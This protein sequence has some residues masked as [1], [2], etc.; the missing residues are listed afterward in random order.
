VEALSA[1]A[2]YSRY[3]FHRQFSALF[4][5]NVHR[6]VLFSRMQRAS[7]LLAFRPHLHVGD[8]AAACGYDGPE[9]FARAFRVLVGDSP[10]G[11]RAQPDW[12]AWSERFHDFLSL[13]RLTM[14]A[15]PSLQDVQIV[16]FPATP[17][18]L[19]THRGDLRTLNDSIRLF[20]DWRK[21]NSVAPRNSATFN[22]LFDDP[23]ATATAD[24]RFGLAAAT[25]RPIEPNDVGVVPMTLPAGRC[26]RLRH[27]G[28][29]DSLE[30]LVRWL[31]GAWLP[32][33]GHEPR[34]FPIFLQRRSFYPDVPAN[35]A[36]T[37]ILLPLRD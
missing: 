33:S 22:I 10:S 37:D 11:F 24:C 7:W 18:G 4:G 28:P 15:D 2:H 31:Y 6:Y 12:L 14:R 20:I 36:V 1:V 9:A 27:H 19:L 8:V 34:D 29:D 17:V 23:A 16:D 25:S 26:A 13:R 32:A 30:H 5:M 21:R 35:E 3:H